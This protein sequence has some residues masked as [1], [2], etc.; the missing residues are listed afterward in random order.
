MKVKQ[1]NQNSLHYL[2]DGLS[3]KKALL[4]ILA[5]QQVDAVLGWQQETAFLPQLLRSHGVIFGMIASNGRYEEWYN[6]ANRVR[7]YLRNMI[8]GRKFRQADVGFIC[9]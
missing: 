6:G 5:E 1:V 4:S 3:V 9:P 2:L 8:V 7:R